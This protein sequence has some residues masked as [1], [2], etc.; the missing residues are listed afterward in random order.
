[1]AHEI[2]VRSLTRIAAM[3][4]TCGGTSVDILS[5]IVVVQGREHSPAGANGQGHVP[6]PEDTV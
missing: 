5:K 2:V 4:N 1:M 6:P 3:R